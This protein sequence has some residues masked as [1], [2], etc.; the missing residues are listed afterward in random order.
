M[1]ERDVMIRVREGLHARPATQ[2]VKLAKSFAAR[3][4]IVRDGRVADAKSSVRLMLLG[5][6]EGDRVTLRA[7]GADAQDAIDSLAAFCADPDAGLSA[8]SPVAS[9]APPPP[10][11]S[12]A[13]PLSGIGASEGIALGP[14]FAFF[15]QPDWPEPVKFP[16]EEVGAE[17]ERF[18]ACLQAVTQNLA[19]SRA[20]PGLKPGDAAI[21]AA[22]IDLACDDELTGAI[23]GRIAAGEDAVTAT[24]AAGQDLARAFQAVA[25][26]YIQGRA[27]DI[28]GITRSIALALAGRT[29]ATLAD[30]PDGA[31]VVAHEIGALDFARA[32]IERIAGILCTHGAATSHIAIMART[33]AIPAV[34]GYAGAEA[35]LKAAGRVALD[36][37]TGE[38]VLDPDAETAAAFTRRSAAQAAERQ[39]LAAFAAIEPRMKDGRLIEIAAN[40]GSLLEIGAAKKAGAMGV[41]LFRTELLFMERAALPDEDEQA[42]VYAELAAAFAPHPVIIRT[43]DVG[44]DKPVAGVDFPREENPFLGWRGVR[45]CLDRPEIFKPQL[46]A[47]LRA[48]LAGNVRVMVPMVTQVDELRAVRALMDGCAAELAQAGVP[49][50]DVALGVMMETPAAALI[51]ADLAREAA[52]FSIGTNDLTQY[53]MAADRLNPRLAALNRVEHPAVMKAVEMICVAARDAGIRVGVC[54]EAAGRPDLIARFIELGVSELSMS[55]ASIAR[56]KKTVVEL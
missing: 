46:K 44:G 41:G 49:H 6:K 30:L 1:L 34:L 10:V 35:A 50:G 52:F 8:A 26:P 54:G 17:R 53:V 3:L 37:A 51:A 11:V 32:P 40:L 22:L 12:T 2:F 20:T 21:V 31:V 18:R 24:L 38:V 27:E 29:D 39:S 19:A 25:D 14:V 16:P 28:R 7:D 47:L 13:A 9:P 56:A 5:V 55:P 33:H 36:G 48:A 43:L 4:E 42:A 45:M 15:P 23:E